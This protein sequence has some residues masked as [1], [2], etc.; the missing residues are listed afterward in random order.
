MG[1]RSDFER[2]E[3][4]FYRTFDR[5]AGKA[6]LPHIDGVQSYIEPFAGRGDLVDQMTELDKL[7]KWQSDMEPQR[8]GIVTLDCLNQ[9]AID[10]IKHETDC[11]L[12]IT[13]PPWERKYF[14]PALDLF[15]ENGFK[16]WWLIDAPWI[17]NKSS[18]PYLKKYVTDIVTIGRLKWVENTTMSGKDDCIWIKTTPYKAKDS[19][20]GFHNDRS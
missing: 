3:R 7:C 9:G 15:T 1:K 17:F 2:V 14:H 8:E 16:G 18:A 12:I 19:G 5:R 6:L 20:V 13:N 11:R 10:H 4:N